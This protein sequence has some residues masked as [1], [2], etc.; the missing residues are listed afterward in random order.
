MKDA[1][2]YDKCVTDKQFSVE[3]PLEYKSL[4]ALMTSSVACRK[5]MW[6]QETGWLGV[7][8]LNIYKSLGF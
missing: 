1:L 3:D 5:H 2:E 7:Q 8:G 4:N 6:I